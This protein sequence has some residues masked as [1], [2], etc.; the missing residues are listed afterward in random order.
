MKRPA[1]LIAVSLAVGILCGPPIAARLPHVLGGC[2]GGALVSLAIGLACPI[3][4]GRKLVRKAE[5][6]PKEWV[7]GKTD[8]AVKTGG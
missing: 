5:G 8:A 2:I 1:L 7:V 6:E 4:F 3:C